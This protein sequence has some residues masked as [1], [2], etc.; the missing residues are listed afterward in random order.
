MRIVIT[1]GALALALSLGACAA[2]EERK[3]P[4]LPSAADAL[5]AVQPIIDCEWKA[6]HR[7]D[8][9]SY[10]VS[11]LANRIMAVCSVERLKARRAMHLPTYG[12]EAELDDFK[13]AVESVE[14]VRK[15]RL[16]K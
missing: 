5:A 2:A 6:V 11:E 3:P 7:L 12:P 16:P 15:S 10:T 4:P 8:N 13:M 9:G 14:S 1:C